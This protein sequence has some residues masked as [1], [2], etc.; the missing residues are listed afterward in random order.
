[1]ID[2]RFRPI[3][4]WPGKRTPAHAQKNGDK[5]FGLSYPKTLISLE[6]ELQYLK[7]RDTVIEGDF[8]EQDIRMDGWPRAGVGP[9]TS[10][11]VLNF[12]SE[13]GPL[14]IPCDYFRRWEH[15]LRAIALHLERLRL[16]NNYGV[17]QHGE[18]VQG[19]EADRGAEWERSCNDRGGGGHVHVRPKRAKFRAQ[20]RQ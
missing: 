14:R 11:V 3:G 18:S 5:V 17:G 20:C 7:A 8:R 1:M 13:H 6:R 12:A 15:N 2:C 16:A 9:R 4:D 10:G 19:L